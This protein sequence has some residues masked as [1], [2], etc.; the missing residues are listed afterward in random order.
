MRGVQLSSTQIGAQGP[1]TLVFPKFELAHAILGAFT[2][3][4]RPSYAG[5]IAWPCQ[6]LRYLVSFQSDSHRQLGFVLGDNGHTCVKS[7]IHTS[8]KGILS[9]IS[10]PRVQKSMPTTVQR[11]SPKD[12]LGPRTEPFTSDLP[13]LIAHPSKT[14]LSLL[15]LSRGLYRGL[16]AEDYMDQGH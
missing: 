8:S 5:C 16:R 14:K 9:E 6:T 13:P 4:S 11:P 1:R 10:T 2:S 12:D 15:I 7:I 3:A